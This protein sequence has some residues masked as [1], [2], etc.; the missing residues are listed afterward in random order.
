MFSQEKFIKTI[1][2]ASKAH[3]GQNYPGKDYSYNV[4]LSIVAMEIVHAIPYTKKKDEIDWDYTMQCAVLHDIIED[5]DITYDEV[6]EEFCKNIADGVLALSKD[7]TIEKKDRMDDSLKR[8]MKQR[9]EVW[10]VKLAD[11]ISNLQPPPPYWN[12]DKIT[13]YRKEAKKICA[14]LGES[15]E[16][17]SKRLEEKIENYK[18]YE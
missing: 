18:K 8:I 11:R 5:T 9:K 16:Y 6:K 10:M 14:L 17:L 1:H 2:F 3:N 15:N 13:N 12:Q 7:Y 4:H